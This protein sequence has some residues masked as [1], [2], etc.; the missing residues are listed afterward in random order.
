MDDFPRPPDIKDVP[1]DEKL[2]M[3]SFAYQAENLSDADRDNEWDTLLQRLRG[4]WGIYWKVVTVSARFQYMKLRMPHPT[5]S[6][7]SVNDVSA[8][9]ELA[10]NPAGTSTSRSSEII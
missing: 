4:R 1:R 7:V 9:P 6:H 2:L 10:T 8:L 3:S 5:W